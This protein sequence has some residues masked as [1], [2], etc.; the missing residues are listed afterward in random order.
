MFSTATDKDMKGTAE[1]CFRFAEDTSGGQRDWRKR[2][3]VRKY[4]NGNER[5]WLVF[6]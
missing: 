1:N 5:Q 6:E 4:S 2:N 3:N